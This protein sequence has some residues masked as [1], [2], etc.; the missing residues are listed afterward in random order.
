MQMPSM[1]L[2]TL[3]VAF[4]TDYKANTR[5]ATFRTTQAILRR[6]ILPYL[7]N[8]PV[9]KI[10]PLIIRTWQG[11]INQKGLSESSKHLIQG[12]FKLI[13]NFGKK[14]YGLQASPFDNI[15]TMGKLTRRLDFIEL[16]DWRRIDAVISDP[17][18]KALYNLLFWSG[19]RI[20]EAMGLTP[21]DFDF[22]KKTVSITK[23]LSTVTRKISP[24]K[25]EN[26]KRLIT[27]PSFV[28]DD[29]KGYFNRFYA[30]PDYPFYVWSTMRIS[31]YFKQYCIKALGKPYNLHALRHSHASLLIHQQVPVNVISK[32]L[33]HSS[34]AITLRIYAH[35][36][37]NADSD[38]AELLENL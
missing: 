22:S 38:V 21:E 29:I 11:E 18:D 10:T 12:K 13:F 31:R 33:G 6:H 9:D 23:Q 17:H 28:L 15:D 5:P 19:M 16:E 34:P 1:A 30:V 20:G 32:R 3:A 36:Y 25:T 35:V 26:S 14:F 4:L 37:K 7:G 24:L 8:M 27:L 2:Q